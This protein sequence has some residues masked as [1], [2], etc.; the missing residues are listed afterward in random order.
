MKYIRNLETGKIE[1]CLEREVYMSL[2]KEKKKMIK[3]NFLFSRRKKAWVSRSKNLKRAIEVAHELGF[4]KEVKIG[5]RL[6]FAEQMQREAERA[7]ARAKRYEKY[8]QTAA[9]RAES[10]QKEFKEY[11][12][13]VAF[14]TQPVIP[15]HSGSERFGRQRQRIIDRYGKGFEEYR[16]SDYFRRKAEV[17]RL[18][19]KQEKWK[20][21]AYLNRKI[22]EVE[23][24]IKQLIKN[25]ERHPEQN[26]IEQLEEEIDKKAFYQNKLDEIGGILFSRENIKAGYIVRIRDTE[27]EVLKANPKTVKVRC[28]EGVLTYDYAEIQEVV[29]AIE[30][31]PKE[32][33][34]PYYKGEILVR[35]SIGGDRIIS[36]YEVIG[37]TPKTIQIQQIQIKKGKPVPGAFLPGSKPKRKKPKICPYKND[38]IV[39]DNNWVLQ[40]L[41]GLD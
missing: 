13:D 26:L 19:A 17:A 14:L 25:L 30:V 8:A 32:E 3:S 38:W 35:T 1:F 36:A 24:N 40:K 28:S 33:T 9:K 2:S 6:T 23:K 15:G 4:T 18:T 39:D 20:N 31:K 11:R 21:P 5:E 34:H 37:R 16:K 7:E 10:L 12:G 27:F 41:R 29:K 22:K